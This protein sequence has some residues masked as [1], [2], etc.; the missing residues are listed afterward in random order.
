MPSN[1]CADAPLE[2]QR[3]R[4][5]AHLALDLVRGVL[6][7]RA[8]LRERL[9]LR[10]GVRRRR[11]LQR[12]LQQALRDEVGVA[13]VGRGRVRVVAHRQ[14][15]V[16]GRRLA[17]PLDDVL[18]GAHQL[19]DREREVREAQRVRP[20]APGQELLERLLSGSGGS[21]SPFSSATLTMR[22]QRSGERTTRRSDGKPL[23]AR[24]RA[25]TPLAAIMKSSISSRARFLGSTVEIDDLVAVEDRA[26]LD[27]LELQR[28]VLVAQLAQLLR[29][30][31]LQA[32]LSRQLRR[33]SRPPRHRHRALERRATAL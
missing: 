15:E 4:R 26:R 21:R 9:E 22:C 3:G 10:R 13:A 20:A 1:R 11:V 27:R 5:L 14:A 19:D 12:G 17:G 33:G 16:A 18:A 7:L 8:V 23:P 29:D 32:Q 6:L 31:V 24:K 2:E 25:V 28:A 30:A